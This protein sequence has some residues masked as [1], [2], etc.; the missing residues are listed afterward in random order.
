MQQLATDGHLSPEIA[1]AFL[2]GLPLHV[3][4]ALE[5]N[6]REINYPVWAVVEMAI[7][8]Y[9]NVDALSFKDLDPAAKRRAN[10]LLE[11]S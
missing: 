3:R 8:G 2:E 7:A 5:K 9:L 11:E 4:D 10:L 6:A 1:Q